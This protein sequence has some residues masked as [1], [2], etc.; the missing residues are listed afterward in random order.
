MGIGGIFRLNCIVKNFDR[1]RS[2]RM[3]AQKWSGLQID[4]NGMD[5]IAAQCTQ[6]L[7]IKF[8]IFTDLVVSLKCL[9]DYFHKIEC[10][11]PTDKF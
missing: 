8:H 1:I 2:P 4:L 9:L 6:Q 10:A 3:R 11:C 5:L 7:K